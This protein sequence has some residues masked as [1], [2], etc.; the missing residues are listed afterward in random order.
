MCV[1]CP[2][3]FNGSAKCIIYFYIFY[4]CYTTYIQW[5]CKMCNIFLY[6]LY[7]CYTTYTQWICSRAS[8]TGRTLQQTTRWTAGHQS[9]TCRKQTFQYTPRQRQNS[10]TTATC[11]AN[12][13]T[14]EIFLFNDAL[15]TF[16]FTVIWRRTYGKGL[17]R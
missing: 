11:S 9:D 10:P 14:N 6:I 4:T 15:K 3:T 1:L 13:I 5:I 2:L 12:V 17:L 8:G 7:V 16:Y